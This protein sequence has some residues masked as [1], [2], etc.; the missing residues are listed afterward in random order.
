VEEVKSTLAILAFALVG[1]IL[2]AQEKK[3]WEVD[4]LCGKL[5]QIQKIPDRKNSNPFSEKRI[6]LRDVA[7]GV[8]ERQENQP[9]CNGLA[10]IETVRTSKGGHFEFKTKKPGNY[11]LST[12]WNSRQYELA[13]SFKSE[14]NPTTM[15]SQQGIALDGEGN[16]DWWITITVD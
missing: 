6:G 9:C 5:E 14:R 3:P 16:A 2:H 4:R 1:Q 7:L 13:V 12:N 11:W 15:C 8:Y 10:T